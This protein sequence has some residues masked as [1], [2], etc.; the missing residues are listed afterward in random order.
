MFSA[1]PLVVVMLTLTLLFVGFIAATTLGQGPTTRPK[2]IPS[3][4][5][6][7]KEGTLMALPD[8]FTERYRTKGF[9]A[10]T[11]GVCTSCGLRPLPLNNLPQTG[12]P[13]VVFVSA[14]ENVY[15]QHRTRL[16]NLHYVFDPSEIYLHPAL[17]LTQTA[18]YISPDCRLISMTLLTGDMTEIKKL[19]NGNGY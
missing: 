11:E 12:L 3:G 4:I 16:K 8:G 15:M 2:P 18:S 17:Y 13:I 1:K 5:V 9:I 7:P 10:L 19:L 6:Y 14:N